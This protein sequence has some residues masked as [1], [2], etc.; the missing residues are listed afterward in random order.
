MLLL[1]WNCG[2]AAALE[3]IGYYGGWDVYQNYTVDN[4]PLG[5]L[6]QL[7][8]A[9]IGLAYTGTKENPVYT[10][11]LTSL[12]PGVDFDY[13]YQCVDLIRIGIIFQPRCH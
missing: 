3:I 5:K 6:K 11:G 12:N 8:Y 1:W 2:E 4:V 10:G 13:A 7:D 9:F